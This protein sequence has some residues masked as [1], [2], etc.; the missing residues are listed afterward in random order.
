MQ[1]KDGGL[2]F[3]EAATQELDDAFTIIEGIVRDSVTALRNAD[4]VI[5]GRIMSREDEIDVLEQRLRKSHIERLNNGQCDPQTT[6]L[7][8][9]MIHTMERISD[10][11][12]NI[13]DVVVSGSHYQVHS[14]VYANK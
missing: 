10:H 5:A 8:L 2:R 4:L 13:A 7:F 3:S 11:C 12:R 9:E 1:M 6:V 14:D